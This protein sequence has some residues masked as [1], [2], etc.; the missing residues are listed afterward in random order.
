MF[1]VDPNSSPPLDLKQDQV[2]QDYQV[3]PLVTVTPLNNPIL[4][5]FQSAESSLRNLVQK[6][7]NQ[8]LIL[9]EKS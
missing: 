4:Q 5:S 1:D 3:N 8:S 9:D 6:P 2:N 7:S